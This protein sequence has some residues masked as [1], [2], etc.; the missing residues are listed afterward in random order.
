MEE[1]TIRLLRELF[2]FVRN[3]GDDD[4][5][6]ILFRLETKSSLP[7]ECFRPLA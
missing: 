1:Q 4:L 2:E 7:P 3:N 5:E 6:N